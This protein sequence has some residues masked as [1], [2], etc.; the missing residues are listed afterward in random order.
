M[1]GSWGKNHVQ[2]ETDRRI[3]F[4]AAFW[5]LKTDQLACFDKSS[6]KKTIWLLRQIG[7]GITITTLE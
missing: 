6:F 2:R 4:E 3:L 5:R 7:F 1:G